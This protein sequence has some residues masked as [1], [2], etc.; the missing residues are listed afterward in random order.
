[1]IRLDLQINLYNIMIQ[2][3]EEFTYRFDNNITAE[4]KVELRDKSNRC[5]GK[6][7]QSKQRQI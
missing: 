2:N 7:L 4:Q 3:F 6:I 1:M 5:L